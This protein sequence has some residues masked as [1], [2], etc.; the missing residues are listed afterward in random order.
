MPYLDEQVADAEQL[1]NFILESNKFTT[2][3]VNGVAVTKVHYKAFFSTKPHE[4]SVF[5]MNGLQDDVV[6]ALG[7]TF[8]GLQREKPIYGWG[9]VSAGTVRET[10]PLAVR[11]D[12][13]PPRHAVIHNWPA[14]VEHRRTLAIQLASEAVATKLR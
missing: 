1:T 2:E 14:D 7:R 12:E 9:R 5:R 8:V 11:A 6:E 4:Q 10:V 13:P 3:L